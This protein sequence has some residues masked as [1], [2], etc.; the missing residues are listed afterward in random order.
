VELLLCHAMVGLGCGSG[1]VG[2]CGHLCLIQAGS[3]SILLLF[4]VWPS[5]RVMESMVLSEE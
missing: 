3:Q 2:K 1:S 4:D 5:G